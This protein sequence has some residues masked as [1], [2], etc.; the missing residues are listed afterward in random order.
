MNAGT[1]LAVFNQNYT[2]TGGNTLAATSGTVG[3]TVATNR[4]LTVNNAISNLGALTVN[5][6]STLNHNIT[7]TAGAGT[8]LN[9]GST[10]IAS[11]QTLNVGSYTTASNG[12]FNLQYGADGSTPGHLIVA[13]GGADFTNTSVVFSQAPVMTAL[14]SPTP[15]VFITATG[16]TVTIPNAN[17]T[18][19]SVL[20]NFVVTGSGTAN[21]SVT[22][23]R[24]G[25]QN[26]L[27]NVNNGNNA[28]VGMSLDNNLTSPNSD[29]AALQLRLINNNTVNGINDILETLTPTVDGSA[30]VASKTVTDQVISLTN[31]RLSSIRAARSGVSSGNNTSRERVWAQPFAVTVDQDAHDGVAGYDAD[32]MGVS[33]GADTDALLPNTITG[34]ALTYGHTNANS[35]NLN[36]TDSDI[37]TYQI[38]AYGDYDLGN[39]AF[40]DGSVGYGYNDIDRTRSNVGGVAGVT[41]NSD[42]HSNQLTAAASV[43][44]TFVPMAQDKAFELT[45]RAGVRY[46]NL[47]TNNYTE[48]GAGGLN[49][50]VDTDTLQALEFSVATE[51]AY[52]INLESGRMTPAL[53]VGYTY[54]AIGDDIQTNAAFTGGGAAFNTNGADPAQ[55]TINAGAALTYY[56]N[57]NWDVSLNYDAQVKSDYVSHAG[58]VKAVYKF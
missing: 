23:V 19:T 34:I 38:T 54:D 7:N 27:G 18:D 53:H 51:A 11:G 2:L 52:N 57:V 3:V 47:N 41:A 43:G 33:V 24:A 14:P 20:Y 1:N 9:N 4:T 8:F 25:M 36:N 12:G 21:A 28:L 48:T 35:D 37:D 40:I 56:T 15:F 44:Q 5:A 42:F 6:G 45:P 58:Y 49:L 22:A 29:I 13:T 50:A 46:T 32:T 26:V 55:S 31:S 30:E 17:V 10:N 16:N 39:R